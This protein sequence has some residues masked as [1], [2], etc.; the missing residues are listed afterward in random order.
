VRGGPS[1]GGARFRFVNP[2]WCSARI[3]GLR[4]AFSQLSVGLRCPVSKAILDAIARDPDRTLDISAN[5]GQMTP[6]MAMSQIDRQFRPTLNG[7]FMERCGPAWHRWA[8][9]CNKKLCFVANDKAYLAY[10]LG[11]L[12]DRPDCYYVKYSVRPRDGMY[13]GRC[14]LMDE[15]AVGMLWAECK[16]DPRM[17]C[18]VQDDDFTAPYRTS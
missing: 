6:E 3:V 1:S 14:F 12:A 10:F 15:H 7:V 13:L 9:C 2:R 5:R 18:S 17:F 11:R 8:Q 16:E 4:V